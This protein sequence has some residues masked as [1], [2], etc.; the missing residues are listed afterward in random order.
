MSTVFALTPRHATTL[1]EVEGHVC[2]REPT[3]DLLIVQ[4]SDRLL[5]RQ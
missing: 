5:I 4:A 3:H 1:M 2:E